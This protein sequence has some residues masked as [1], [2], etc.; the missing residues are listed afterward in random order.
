MRPAEVAYGLPRS[1]AQAWGD[2]PART[3][4]PSETRMAV[5]RRLATRFHCTPDELALRL[6]SDRGRDSSGSRPLNDTELRSLEKPLA[7]AW[8]ALKHEA[9]EL[10]QARRKLAKYFPRAIQRRLG[11]LG[12][13]GTRLSVA[14]ETRELE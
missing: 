5:Y 9:N 10:T 8:A 3:P 2:D 14:V 13:G 12:L 7:Q 6:A 4:R 1:L 11:P